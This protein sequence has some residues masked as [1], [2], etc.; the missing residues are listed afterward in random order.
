MTRHDERKSVLVTGAGGFVGT[1]LVRKLLSE[2]YDVHIL[3][4]NQTSSWRLKDIFNR[5]YVHT[6]DLQDKKSL[7]EVLKRIKPFAI[8]HMAAHGCYPTQT[9]TD[10]MVSANILGTQN[11]LMASKEIPYSCF[12][13]TGSSSEYGFK[14]KAMKEDDYC[15]PVSY[16]AATKLSATVLGQV[17]ARQYNKPVIIFRLFSVYGPFEEPTRLIPT[18]IQNTINK[19]PITLSSNIARR[20][21]IHVD[22]V[23]TAYLKGIKK[24]NKFKGQIFNIGTGKETSN[25]EVVEYLFEGVKQ[26]VQIRKDINKSR[27]WDTPHWRASTIRSK[28]LLGWQA[29]INLPSGLKLTYQWFL[30]NKKLYEKKK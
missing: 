16:Y 5:L 9:D 14:S 24:A 1:N 3:L 18:V 25:E 6:N 11:L 22:D 30:E 21:F 29:K 12:I 15:E 19:K 8:F 7:E 10:K 20:D 4:K 17:F 26:K 13:I 23:T 28:S 2:N 27:S